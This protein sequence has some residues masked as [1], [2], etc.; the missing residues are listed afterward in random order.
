[1]SD[2]FQ[3][4]EE[5]YSVINTQIRHCVYNS[6]ACV[7]KMI[8]PNVALP[9]S[10]KELRDLVD[11]Y[12]Q[13]ITEADIPLAP[14]R[15]VENQAK[16]LVYVCRYV[17]KNLIDQFTRDDLFR[18]SALPILEQIGEVLRKA[19]AFGLFLD[20]HPKNFTWDGSSI[21]YV[22]FC[23]PYIPEYIDL[24]LQVA[25]KEERDLIVKNFT[26]FSPPYLFAHFVGDFFNIYPDFPEEFIANV[27]D[28]FVQKDLVHESYEEF[29]SLARKI[30]KLEDARL[31]KNIYLF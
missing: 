21:Y 9:L 25:E 17:G 8:S 26:Y 6:E 15:H 12:I 22:D 3:H 31:E 30:R 19:Q 4:H 16:H 13:Q 10:L 24:R 29:R 14:I 7:E 2:P 1:M 5:S 28:W 11:T 20:P 18:L 23:P 27:Y